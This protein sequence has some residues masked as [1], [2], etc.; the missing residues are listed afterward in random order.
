[1]RILQA[2]ISCHWS[3]AKQV[4]SNGNPLLRF[5]LLG[6]I[7]HHT[8][9]DKITDQTF[10]A[11]LHSLLILIASPSDD[12]RGEEPVG[13][14]CSKDALTA[15]FMAVF[16]HYCTG[17]KPP[18]EFEV[19]QVGF[20]KFH[21]FSWLVCMLGYDLPPT[22][23]RMISE[24]SVIRSLVEHYPWHA[25]YGLDLLFRYNLER[26]NEHPYVYP[27]GPPDLQAQEQKLSILVDILSEE[28]QLHGSQPYWEV[29]LDSWRHMVQ[30][31]HRAL[32]LTNIAPVD[33]VRDGE[34]G[35]GASAN[36]S[37]DTWPFTIHPLVHGSLPGRVPA[38][39]RRLDFLHGRYL[40]TTNESTRPPQF[41]E[42][43]E[44]VGET[45]PTSFSFMSLDC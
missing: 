8:E 25:S 15:R 21:L 1:M 42:L 5:G 28:L 7:I 30:E 29:L 19:S 34:V 22:F 2:P 9:T 18:K 23:F 10:A 38:L 3:T 17:K 26:D 32:K 33:I 27:C 45:G 16:A 36:D 35:E 37:S 40:H 24:A 11:V 6:D 13:L 31:R 43:D 12:L 41:T 39:L 14:K 44:E 4:A 20:P